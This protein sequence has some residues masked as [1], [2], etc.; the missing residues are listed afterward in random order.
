MGV[1]DSLIFGVDG[2]ICG[3]SGTFHAGRIKESR[4][5]ANNPINA[6]LQTR[7]RVAAAARRSSRLKSHAASNRIAPF[8]EASSRIVSQT[9]GADV[10]TASKNAIMAISLLFSPV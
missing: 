2:N 4:G 8:K 9:V 6:K 1:F 3:A 7:W 10:P 5:K